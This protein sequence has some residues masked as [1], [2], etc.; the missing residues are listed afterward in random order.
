VNKLIALIKNNWLAL[1]LVSV[2]TVTISSLWPVDQLPQ[3][4]G[5]DKLHHV[6]AYAMVMF[7]IALRRPERW[8]WFG[9]LVVAYS[10]GI[11]LVQPY[12]NRYAEWLDL[13]ANSAGV[14]SAVV[15]AELINRVFPSQQNSQNGH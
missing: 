1:T 8:V 5:T 3:V 14:V 10:G 2:V 4:P 12:M 11:E 13:L 9:L 6:I 15:I 7:P